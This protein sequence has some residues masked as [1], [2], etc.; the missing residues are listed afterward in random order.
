MDRLQFDESGSVADCVLAGVCA[1]GRQKLD[2]LAARFELVLLGSPVRSG[3]D[4]RKR[5]ALHA[6]AS[7]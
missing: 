2:L 3:R 5:F 6:F 1:F 4:G 7:D